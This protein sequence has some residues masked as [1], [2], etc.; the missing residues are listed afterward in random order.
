MKHVTMAELEAGLKN[1]RQSPTDAG[2]LALIV[3]RPQVEAREVLEV[4]ELDLF[5]GL[6]G[7][8]W[9]TRGSSQTADGSAH[10][11]MQLNIMNAR[12]IAL[13][14]Q[15][16]ERW[17]LAGD[18][19]YM[20]LDLSAEN[21]PPGTRLSLGEAVIEV[22]DQPHTG[23]KKFAA[24]FGLDALKFISSPVGKQLQLRGINA[25]VIRSGAIRIGDTVKKVKL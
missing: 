7:D 18:Q 10:P 9:K 4:G 3:R 11:D 20:D 5:E 6:V 8:N 2:V 13:L 25:K 14:A 23:C 1:I 22:T 19:L 24:R 12:V 15:Q 17:A 21:V 16:K